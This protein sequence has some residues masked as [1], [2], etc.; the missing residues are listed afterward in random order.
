[1]QTVI[2]NDEEP[3]PPI[4]IYPGVARKQHH[5]TKKM[6]FPVETETLQKSVGMILTQRHQ[7]Y[8]MF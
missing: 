8:K 1:M 6:L 2:E 5:L 3:K 7:S 4:C